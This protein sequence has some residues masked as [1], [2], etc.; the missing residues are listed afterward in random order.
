M[1]DPLVLSGLKRKRAE[2]AGIIAYHKGQIRRQK[3][4]LAHIDA[5]IKLWAPATRPNRIPAKKVYIRNRCFK[6]GELP[7]LCLELL[8]NATE[9]M[10]TAELG[11]AALARKGLSTDDVHTVRFAADRTSMVMAK[12]HKR[13]LVERIEGGR[14]LRWS[15]GGEVISGHAPSDV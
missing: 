11:M 3:A 5:A 12:L 8:R 10:T 6:P 7:R 2:I 14:V 13:G 4:N 9:P 15:I 1:A